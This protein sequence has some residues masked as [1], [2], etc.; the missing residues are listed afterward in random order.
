MKGRQTGNW[1][2]WKQHRKMNNLEIWSQRI[3]QDENW[4]F[5]CHLLPHRQQLLVRDG[6]R[7]SK[8]TGASAEAAW[9]TA[10]VRKNVTAS[11]VTAAKLDACALLHSTLRTFVRPGAQEW[12][13]SQ[14]FF[15]S[16]TAKST[17]VSRQ[18][19]C[20]T[21]VAKTWIKLGMYHKF[22][23]YPAYAKPI[24]KTLKCALLTLP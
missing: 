13:T 14:T 17:Y 16:T 4:A 6:E 20:L 9:R 5:P 22:I 15:Q 24:R 3:G 10:P 2:G 8:M 7:Y 1:K 11:C 12:C 23:Y 21:F 18:F 19:L